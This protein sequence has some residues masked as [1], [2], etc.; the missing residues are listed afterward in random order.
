[1]T[2]FIENIEGFPLRA[3]TLPTS[4]QVDVWLMDL[5]TMPMM[6]GSADRNNAAASPLA[7][8]VRDLRIRQQFFLRLLF[9]RYLCKPGKDIRL[10]KTPEGKPFLVD[11]KVEINISHTRG[12]LVVAVSGS[13]PVGIDVEVDRVIKRA[14]PMARRCYA[15]EEAVAIEAL[16]EPQRSRAF[17]E[18]WIRTEALVKA[19]GA[20]L[21]SSLAGLTF[22][23]PSFALQST[24]AN[25]P[26]HDQWTI[27]PLPL[28]SPLIGA[29]AAAEAIDTVYLHQVVPT[30]T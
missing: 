13:T 21:A 28:P 15:T 14:G 20:R 10:D 25:W 17:L 9:G 8:G 5:A 29:L 7:N 18:R 19:Q 22:D 1:M 4:G 2:A 26:K 23:H 11:E 27:A 12:W 16:D 3:L 6:T 24:P 30:G